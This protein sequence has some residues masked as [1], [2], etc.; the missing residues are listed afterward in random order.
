MMSPVT[1]LLVE[2]QAVIGADLEAMLVRSAYQVCG[3]AASGDEALEM[4]RRHR[5]QLVLMD[6]RIQ[7]AMDGVETAKLI[8]RE[9]DVPIIFLSAHSD[10]ATL[11]RAKRVAP[12]GFLIKP[13]DERELRVSIEVALTKHAGERQLAVAYS[14]IRD[15]NLALKELAD[16]DPLTGLA[17]R[18]QFTERFG[19]EMSRVARSAA[20]LSVLMIDIDHFKAI[21]DRHGHLAGDACI[22]S[23]ADVLQRSLRAVDLLARFGGDEFVALLPDTTVA[24]ALL[25]GER[26]RHN[27]QLCATATEPGNAPLQVTVSIGAATSHRGDSMEHMLERADKALYASK[28]LGRNRVSTFPE[29]ESVEGEGQ[30]KKG[31]SATKLTTL[32]IVE[33]Q[34]V[35]AADLEGQLVRNGYAVCGIAASGEQA[36][37]LARQC[38]PGLALMDIRIQGDMDGIETAKILRREMDIPVII[39]SAHSDEATVQRAK[40]SCPYGFLVKPFDERELRINIEVALHKHAGE[41]ELADAYREIQRLNASLEERVLQRT[42]QLQAALSEI[43]GFVHAAAHHLRTPLRAMEGYAHLLLSQ[44]GTGLPKEVARFPQAIASNARRAAQLVDHLLAFVNLR[45]QALCLTPV[46]I[47]AMAQAV[48][49]EL[50]AA[51]PQRRV[52]MDVQ[53]L[54]VCQADAGLLRKVLEALLSNALKFSQH[55]PQANIVVGVHAAPDAADTQDPSLWVYFVRDNGIGID[56]RYADNLFTLFSQLNLPEQYEGTGAGLAMA[57]RMVERMGGH[58]WFTSAPDQGATFFFTLARSS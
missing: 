7:G 34:A 25:A 8:R 50:L 20:P 55:R 42:A 52:H 27:V 19:L 41:R 45:Q 44:H 2:D 35:V 23:L 1:L 11:Q 29:P 26:M 21:N 48:V 22:Q 46:D 16:H 9:M 49:D 30:Q 38:R 43:E 51:T 12:H 39:L 17:N 36:L 32:L 53:A 37:A 5:P 31:E 24:M 18:R 10:E 47:H 40:G 54:P 3:V 6:I 13:F 28:L 4:A 57:R 14:E 58:I 33:D 56:A 15:A